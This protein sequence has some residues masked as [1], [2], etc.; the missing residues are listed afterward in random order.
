MADLLC[1][2]NGSKTVEEIIADTNTQ[3]K[4]DVS[5]KLISGF[6]RLYKLG[7]FNSDD[8][9]ANDQSQTLN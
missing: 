4:K 1:K 9:Y 8:N 7:I 5:Q 6:E 2:L 3:V